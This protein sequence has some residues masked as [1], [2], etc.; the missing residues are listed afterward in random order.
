MNDFVYHKDVIAQQY[1]C[2]K[3]NVDT[4]PIEQRTNFWTAILMLI[5]FCFLEIIGIQGGFMFDPHTGY[6]PPNPY[7]FLQTL[8]ICALNGSAALGYAY[9]DF[10]VSSAVTKLTAFA[11]LIC[12]GSP[13]LVY[14]IL[15]NTVRNE[16]SRLLGG[17]VF[18]KI[19]I[20]TEQNVLPSLDVTYRNSRVLTQI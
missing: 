18:S 9:E 1:N 10:F 19:K 4:I 16:I 13:A 17:K 3:Y 12:Q 8:I 2:S 7:L 5:I 11:Y 20:S 15:N 6:L 14:I